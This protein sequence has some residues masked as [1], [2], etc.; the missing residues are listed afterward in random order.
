M[1]F[2][3]LVGAEPPVGV[4]PRLP[5]NDLEIVEALGAVIAE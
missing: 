1:T 4:E 2:D 5:G 3:I